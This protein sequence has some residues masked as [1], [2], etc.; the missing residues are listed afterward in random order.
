M[1]K[2]K[3]N[4]SFKIII[5]PTEI[6]CHNCHWHWKVK[7]GG[8]DLF[9]CHKCY[10]DNSKFYK[11]EDGALIIEPNER[12]QWNGYKIG[13][14]ID[15]SKLD[16]LSGNLV[17]NDNKKYILVQQDLSI[18]PYSRQDLIDLDPD[19]Q[20]EENWRIESMKQNFVKTP[21]IPQ[22][23]DGMHRIISAKELGHKTILMWKEYHSNNNFKKGGR[24]I[25]QTP[26]PKKDQ[27]KGS[28]K[29][30]VGSSKDTSSA[31]EIK[32][33][34]EL[35]ETIQNKV[36]S[37]NKKYS[38]KKITL[39]SA[40]AV[41]RRGMGAYSNTYRPTISGGKPN[42]RVAWGLARLNA[43]LYKIVNGKSKSGKYSQDNDLIEELGYK[44]QKFS[45]GGD[46]QAYEDAMGISEFKEGGETKPKKV[47]VS[48]KLPFELQNLWKK[49]DS[50][51]NFNKYFYTYNEKPFEELKNQKLEGLIGISSSPNNIAEWFIN[52]DCLIV[53]NYDEFIEI[54]ETE[55]INYYDPYQLMKNNL[56]L[57]KRLYANISARSNDEDSSYVFSQTLI[58]ILEKIIREINL[59]MNLAEGQK[60]SELYRISRFLSPYETKAFPNWIEKN[61]IKIE[62]PIDLT[63]AILDFNKLNDNYLG[64]GFEN[65]ILTFD[66]L[67]PV[68]EKGITNASSIYDSEQEIVL[69]N[70]ELNIPK[71]S[72]LFF[73]G[74]NELG[75]DTESNRND[76]I[77]KY[78]LNDLYKIYY[79]DRKEIEKYRSIWLKKADEKFNKK[80]E[81][82]R[83]ELELKKEQVLDEL[84]N[85][86][87]EKSINYVKNE[88][89]KEYLEY[90]ESFD[91]Y[92]ETSDDYIEQNL[93]S[94]PLVKSIMNTYELIIKNFWKAFI[95]KKR[96]E[97]L[98]LYAFMRFYS[99][100]ESE[101][102][103]YFENQKDEL[104]KLN[105]YRNTTGGSSLDPYRFERLLL[106]TINDYEYLPELIDYKELS[107]MYLEKMGRE[108][109][110]Y[111]DKKDLNLISQYEDG[112]ETN[113]LNLI[114]NNTMNTNNP[115]DTITM[116]IPLLI[117]FSELMREDIKT[118]VALH[119]VIEN[120]LNIKDRGVL[121]MNDYE[122]IIG[123]VTSLEE[124]KLEVEK[125]EEGGKVN[126]IKSKKGDIK[127]SLDEN[128]YSDDTKVELVPVSELIKFR[129]FDRKVKPKYNQD[130]SRDNINHLKYM[131]EKNGVQEPLII[132]Y[133]PQDNA[134]LLI[135]GNHRLN[136]AIDLG[137]E[138]LPARVVLRKYSPF[139][140]NQIKNTIKVNGVIADESGYISSDLKPSI[141]GIDG[142]MPIYR[143]GGIIEGKLHSECDDDG[144]GRKF[145]VGENGHIIEA[146]RDEAVIV[147]DAFE[148]EEEYT[149]NGNPS[150]V[151]S[152][153]NVMGGGKNFDKGAI[154]IKNGQELEI[155][156]LKKQATETDVD[157][158]IDPSSIIIN[159]RSMADEKKYEVTGTPK[160]IA[161]AINSING[162]G[163]VIEK[164][165]EIKQN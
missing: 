31:K 23:G 157:D 159:R 147:A 123:N 26:A 131:F 18:Y 14:I 111:Y 139:S 103:N 118:D 78:V 99:N 44:V 102:K 106:K 116:N 107:K 119:E 122:N 36:D 141:V 130:N 53:M 98:D 162:N 48:I 5:N 13:D 57:F 117:R 137:M 92:D 68:I 156:E 121:T 146:E 7:D 164:G 37:H 76:L 61:E 59:E 93:F 114:K 34:D 22:D 96:V 152:A 20:E 46:I 15:G 62:S 35:L 143:D 84:L 40:K 74:K 105:N 101:L 124:D 51:E 12:I 11:F 91:Y 39:D 33:S 83:E 144:C 95:Q 28:D 135:E 75:E 80:L 149:I 21:P 50:L 8:D 155:P 71:N 158:I 97:N 108:I 65:P 56:Y 126:S 81:Q 104:E 2:S 73:I 132:E 125:M 30:K 86:F 154:I 4:D 25:S 148:D 1:N 52:R 43:F 27:I 120:L 16:E 90:S 115:E 109:Y 140:P 142:T 134:V 150:E 10:Y 79:V 77:E 54:N 45:D 72:Q 85:L 67:L 55:T 165:A 128:Y 94:I 160:Q 113:E 19:Y 69:T 24:T 6:E 82:G 63:N 163:V 70:R 38:N 58:K 89:E 145:Q 112:G 129:E 64:S 29:N 49:G 41:V 133:S 87:L 110:R 100:V 42:S 17:G 47:Y 32:F 9:I 161:S 151:A 136:S 60:Y 127:L 138:Y 88:L 3:F 66:E 153:L